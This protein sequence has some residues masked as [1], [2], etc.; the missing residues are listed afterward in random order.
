LQRELQQ[1]IQETKQAAGAIGR[2]ADVWELE[3]LLTQR[4]K[5]INRKYNFR[6]SHLKEVL[7][8]L[9]RE[10]RGAKRNCVRSARKTGGKS[11]PTFNFLPRWIQNEGIMRAIAW[12]QPLSRAFC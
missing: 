6:Q 1:V 12:S 8:Q 3:E 4:R 7:G 10:K 11:A 9:L 2:P 5:E